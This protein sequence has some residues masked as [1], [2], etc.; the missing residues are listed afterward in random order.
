MIR[1][2]VQ[3]VAQAFLCA[4]ARRVEHPLKNAVGFQPVKYAR[5]LA[6]RLSHRL[7]A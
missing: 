3:H 4:L 2:D 6:R 5:N 1:Y 7:T